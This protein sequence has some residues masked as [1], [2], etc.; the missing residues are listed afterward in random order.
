MLRL[1]PSMLWLAGVLAFPSRAH[2]VAPDHQ[3]AAG[4][5]AFTYWPAVGTAPTYFG[6]EVS[7]HLAIGPREG[8]KPF[9]IGGG[10]RTAAPVPTVPL[11]GYLHAQLQGHFGAWRPA[12]GPEV[13]VSG[14]ARPHLVT[15]GRPDGGIGT[16]REDS[17]GLGYLA[18]AASPLRFELGRWTLV[19][20]EGHIGASFPPLGGAVR[21]QLGLVQIGFTL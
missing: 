17:L 8:A 2:A 11:E 6:G 18:F 7:Y 15:T 21:A 10:V 20:L 16:R 13:G 1:F 12:A 4:A 5:V 9:R 3:L 14:F 19:A